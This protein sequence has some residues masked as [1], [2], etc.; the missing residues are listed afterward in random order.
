MY[1]FGSTKSDLVAYLFDGCPAIHVAG[2]IRIYAASDK[3]LGQ[4]EMTMSANQNQWTA[5][6][7]AVKSFVLQSKLTSRPCET[8]H[9]MTASLLPTVKE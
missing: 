1:G 9:W 3:S 4:R 6:L 5:F 2:E 8:R 7:I